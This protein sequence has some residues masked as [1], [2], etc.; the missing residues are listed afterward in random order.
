MVEHYGMYPTIVLF[1]TGNQ[2]LPKSIVERRQ[3][4]FEFD[5]PQKLWFGAGR[6]AATLLSAL[7]V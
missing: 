2:A 1:K 3:S 7:L 6:L 5:A 4:G